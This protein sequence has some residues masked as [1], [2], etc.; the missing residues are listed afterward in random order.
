[1]TVCSHATDGRH[2]LRNRRDQWVSAEPLLKVVRAREATP[3]A[4]DPEGAAAGLQR[5]R[6]KVGLADVHQP[7]VLDVSR[8]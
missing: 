7:T 3:V 5:H 4:P 2:R 1:M 8:G 6:W